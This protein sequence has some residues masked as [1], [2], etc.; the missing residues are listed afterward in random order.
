MVRGFAIFTLALLCF[1]G[2]ASAQ[3]QPPTSTSGPI[4]AN[5]LLGL[6]Q[7]RAGTSFDTLGT[8]GFKVLPNLQINGELGTLDFKRFI[9]TSEVRVDTHQALRYGG[10]AVFT[11][12]RP[13][14]VQPF[15]LAGVGALRTDAA[16]GTDK[17]TSPYMNIGVGFDFWAT[18]WVGVGMQYRAYFV[19][20]GTVHYFNAGARIGLH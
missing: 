10:T 5:A 16:N 19:D 8:V 6:G 18:K 20:E 11:Y 15:L 4:V 17:E 14:I 7:S 2:T 9:S 12:S 13:M 1:A 3:S